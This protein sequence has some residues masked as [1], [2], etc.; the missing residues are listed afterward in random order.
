LAPILDEL[1]F[2]LPDEYSY[3][4][5]FFTAV[6][7]EGEYMDPLPEE[8]GLTVGFRVPEW[9]DPGEDLTILW[10]DGLDWVDLGGEYS[11]DGYYFQITTEEIGV[12]VLAVQ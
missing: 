6:L 7:D 8:S 11:E 4:S 5:V 2:L 3:A 1:P 9:L 12:F 10:W